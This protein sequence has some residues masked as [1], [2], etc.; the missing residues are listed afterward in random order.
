MRSSELYDRDYYAWIQHQVQA[1]RER[2]VEDIDWTNA[3][4]E[5]E[6]LGKSERRGIRS[7]LARLLEYLLKLQYARGT[8][9]A[10]NRR[11]WELSIKGARIAVDDLL[12]DSPSLRSQL[13]EMVAQAYRTARLEALR[14]ARLSD[15]AI[16]ESSPWTVERV[17][18]DNFLPAGD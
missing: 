8:F 17:M 3:A 14:K 10:N 11:G 16:P 13:P 6:D 7:Q 5:I 9:R 4:E 12:N 2:R 15:E 18:D 1:L